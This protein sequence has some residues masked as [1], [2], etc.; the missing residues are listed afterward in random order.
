MLHNA[1]YSVKFNKNSRSVNEVYGSLTN[2]PPTNQQS[3]HCIQINMR[4]GTTNI[5]DCTTLRQDKELQL[6]HCN[7]WKPRVNKI[8]NYMNGV[9]NE[10]VTGIKKQIWIDMNII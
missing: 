5:N 6:W 1:D 10:F 2:I 7:S 8:N 4:G 3:K 9:G